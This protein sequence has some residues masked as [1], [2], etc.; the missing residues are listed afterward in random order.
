VTRIVILA[1]EG[2]YESDRT[3]GGVADELRRQLPGV[4]V[5]YRTANPLEDMPAFPASSFGD[6]TPLRE[7]D[8]LVV[9]TRFRILPDE[10]MEEL[11]RYL[12]RGGPVVGLRTSTHAFHYEAGSD[13]A[14]WND[15]FGRDVLGTPWISHHG[16]ASHTIVTRPADVQHP[17]L[18]GVDQ[19]FEVRSWLYHTELSKPCSVLL[20]GEPVDPECPPT[21][22]A[23]AWT[24]E[25]NGGRV[26]YTS[27]GHPED[28][29]VPPFR[30]L[31]RNGISWCA[32]QT[33]G[34]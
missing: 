30:R 11:E 21:P 16:H 24:T 26:F 2:E 12:E 9:Y 3:M 6:L 22:G 29:E 19:H 28:F 20:R 1:G 5:D 15:G 14:D 27:L 34:A 10:E 33:R 25:H 18:D 23:V 8:V 31:L 7:A 32:D 4:V 17:I 13:W